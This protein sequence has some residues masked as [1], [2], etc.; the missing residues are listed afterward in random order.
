MNLK[1]HNMVYLAVQFNS[2]IP[3]SSCG[4]TAWSVFKNALSIVDS[5]PH[6][7]RVRNICMENRK[8]SLKFLANLLAHDFTEVGAAVAH[9]QQDAGN[10]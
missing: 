9:R 2:K 5:F 3:V 4:R 1:R 7:D 10:F 8:G 6:F